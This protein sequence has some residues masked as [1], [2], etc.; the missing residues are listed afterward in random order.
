MVG[1]ENGGQSGSGALEA[2]VKS[3]CRSLSFIRRTTDLS[4]LYRRP[5][6][7]TLAKIEFHCGG[8][9]RATAASRPFNALS[10]ASLRICDPTVCWLVL[11]WI[12]N[13]RRA[14]SFY[15]SSHKC[16]QLI[17]LFRTG[18][19][20]IDRRVRYREEMSRYM[21]QI[22]YSKRYRKITINMNSIYFYHLSKKK[23]DSTY[24]KYMSKSLSNPLI[25]NENVY[26]F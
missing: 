1:G 11:F 26:S 9:C 20:R 15:F 13:A 23:G 6:V 22:N 10:A 7:P 17:H 4:I 18:T 16:T 21:A 25:L 19:L 12:A 5:F 24:K 3:L 14:R 8:Y 2:P